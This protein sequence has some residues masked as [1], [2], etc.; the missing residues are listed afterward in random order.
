[1]ERGI[2]RTSDGVPKY[3]GSPELFAAY[4][5]EAVQYLMTIEHK[6]RYVVAPRLLKELEGTAKMAVRAMNLRDPQWVAK[7]RGGLHSP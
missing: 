5:E 4:R 7:P 2:Q 1:M 6:K 3:D